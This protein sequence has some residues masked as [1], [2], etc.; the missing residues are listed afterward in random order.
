[1]SGTSVTRPKSAGFSEEIPKQG[2]SPPKR[3]L[4]PGPLPPSKEKE[5]PSPKLENSANCRQNYIVTE[6]FPHNKKAPNDY[7]LHQRE[8]AGE[9]RKR[10]GGAIKI[11]RG[12]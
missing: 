7:N 5:N 4:F 10:G 2:E 11:E 3:E 6:F 8:M 12:V 9:E 1:V